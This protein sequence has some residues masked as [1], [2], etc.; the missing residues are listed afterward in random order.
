MYDRKEKLRKVFEDTQKYYTEDA[1]LKAAVDNSR[2]NARVYPA[3]Q[4]PDI[5]GKAAD[6]AGKLRVTRSRTFEAAMK[7]HREFPDKK[8]A[9]LNFASATRPGGGVTNGAG[10]QEECLCRCSTLY[11]TLNT[12]YMWEHFYDVNRAMHDVMH[13]D[14]C[15]YSPGIVICKTDED[16]PQRME[17]DKHVTVDV[18]SC[19]APNLRNLP[20]NAYNPESGS[21]VSA[22]PDV[23][24]KVHLQRARQIMY[25]AA[26][27]DADILVLGAFGCGAFRNDPYAVAEAYRTAMDEH[28]GLFDLV[29]FAVYCSDR[30]TGNYEAFRRKL[31]K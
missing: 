21:A 18:I 24:Y 1:A 7:L 15:I 4:L 23:Q 17:P 14:A 19:A 16:I 26:A 29:E 9:V 27:N 28:R 20:A 12:K 31:T 11:P 3:G 13:T 22:T 30:D 5:A 10:A 2:K 25:V 8:T 6:R